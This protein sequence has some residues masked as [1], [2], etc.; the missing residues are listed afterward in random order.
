VIYD[1]DIEAPRDVR[2]VVS[3]VNRGDVRVE[4][5]TGDFDIG[6]VNGRI[7]IVDI[8]GSGDIHT[9][10]GPITARFVK[11]PAGPTSFKSVNGALDVYFQPDFSADLRFK[12]LNGQIYSDFEVT[13]SLLPTGAA[14]RHD[15]KFVYRSNGLKAAR[16]GQGGPE[17]TFNTLNGN[18][19]L[20]RE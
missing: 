14:E 9:V 11:N 7:D 4:G 18:I 15:G 3:T 5:T 8:A 16:A 20:H 6:N 1:L 2:P 19:R 17:L 10:N 13:A 12:T